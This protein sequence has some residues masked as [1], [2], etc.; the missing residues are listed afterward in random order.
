MYTRST[1][2]FHAGTKGM[3]WGRRL[4]QNKD[5]SLTALGRIRYGKGTGKTKAELAKEKA[6]AEKKAAKKAA[7]AEEKAK[8]QEKKKSVDDMSDAELAAAIKRK[9]L[10]Q[11]YS[12]LNPKKVSLGKRFIDDSVIPAA[13]EAGRSLLKDTFVKYGK[14]YLGLEDDV[15]PTSALKKSVDKLRLE[16]DKVDLEDYLKDIDANREAARLKRE[17]ENA[18]NKKKIADNDASDE[19]D[20]GKKKRDEDEE[21]DD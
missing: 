16:K 18:K 8:K 20:D 6:K 3:K 19:K 13:T 21:D 9:Q 5:G 14:K 4:Y 11:Q 17:A 12:Q 1:E 2:L 15:D 10:E 7:K